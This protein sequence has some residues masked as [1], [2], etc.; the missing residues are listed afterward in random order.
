[1]KV[2]TESFY[3]ATFKVEEEFDNVKADLEETIQ[4]C[5]DKMLLKVMDSITART[6]RSVRRREE[7]LAAEYWEDAEC[8]V[9][10]FSMRMCMCL[11]CYLLV[12][13]LL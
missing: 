9:S 13:S 1:M 8:P 2:T 10:L 7:E 6:Q 4:D 12:A 5:C 11:V 3:E